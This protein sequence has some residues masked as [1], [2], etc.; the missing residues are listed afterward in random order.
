MTPEPLIAWDTEQS[1]DTNTDDL[2]LRLEEDSISEKATSIFVTTRIVDPIHTAV[3]ELISAFEDDAETG[4][5]HLDNFRVFL[6]AKKLRNE[7]PY[8]A[9][10]DGISLAEAGYRRDKQGWVKDWKRKE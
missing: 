4:A 5:L 2:L 8:M 3:L 7:D 1:A 9:V 6:E 10:V